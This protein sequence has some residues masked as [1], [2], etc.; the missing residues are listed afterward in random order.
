M[1][2]SRAA[3]GGHVDVHAHYLPG[4]YLEELRR[5]GSQTTGLVGNLPIGDAPGEVEARLAAMDAAGIRLQV[6]SAGP[7][8]P[9]LADEGDAL[10]AA[11][12]SNDLSARLAAA[13]PG[14]FAGFA[15]TPLPHVEAA[16]KELRRAMDELGMLGIALP[17]T[18][19]GVTLGDPRWEP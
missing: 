11:R 3:R 12:L 1:A 5:G 14:R 7:Q 18:I 10:R 9:L 8:M 17:T 19:A 15:T 16:L 4:T 13:H 2:A 6:L